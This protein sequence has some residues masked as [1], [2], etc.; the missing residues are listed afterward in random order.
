ITLR[1]LRIL[2]EVEVIAAEDTRQTGILL[3]HFEIKTRQISYHKF[4]ENA[5]VHTLLDI[6]RNG[7]DVAIV[8]DAGSPG[9]SDPAQIIVK[10]AIEA[11]VPVCALPGATAL[12]PALTAS[13]FTS[14]TFCFYGFLPTKRSLRTKLLHEIQHL[15]HT[16]VIYETCPKLYNTLS[17][18]LSICGNRTITIAREISKLYEE[19]TRSDIESIL[20]NR[21][22]TLKGELVLVIGAA[23]DTETPDIDCD[24]LISQRLA[25]GDKVSDILEQLVH[26]CNMNKNEAY[27]R[28]LE[29]KKR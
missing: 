10:A 23:T 12:I 19:Y 21:S 9:I 18:I 26:V 22:I 13:G 7:K 27:Q 29:Q 15:H 16:S 5:R 17:D 25:A 24:E 4:N 28:I 8:S 1:A 6:L 14:G 2:K 20:Q 11:S 3:K